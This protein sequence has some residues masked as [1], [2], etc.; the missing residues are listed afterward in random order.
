MKQVAQLLQKKAFIPEYSY[1]VFSDAGASIFDGSVGVIYSPERS[2]AKM[3]SVVKRVGA[4]ALSDPVQFT[5]LATALENV[6]DVTASKDDGILEVTFG[7]GS[8]KMAVPAVFDLPDS[9]PHLQIRLEKYNPEQKGAFQITP[10]WKD[11]ATLLTNAGESLWQNQLGLYGRNSRLMTFDFGVFAISKDEVGFDGE[12]FVPR[13]VLSLG[14]HE[15]NYGRVQ[16]GQIHLVGSNLQ[17]VCPATE[18]TAAVEEQAKIAEKFDAGEQFPVTISPLSGVWKRAEA[19]AFEAVNLKIEGGQLILQSGGWS[20]SLGKTGAPE[21]EVMTYLGLLKRWASRTLGH[22]ISK[23]DDAWFLHGQTRNGMLFYAQ[24]TGVSPMVSDESE[25]ELEE[26]EEAQDSK[27]AESG[28]ASE[29][30]LF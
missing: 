18:I 28:Q 1:M 23:L 8:G 19:F 7:G 12:F 14:V 13:K 17:Y 29:F 3:M 26:T 25:P 21:I 24:L 15:L 22:S 4:F 6:V 30:S 10:A 9:V 5:K 11:A 20:E 27:V 16:G 2:G